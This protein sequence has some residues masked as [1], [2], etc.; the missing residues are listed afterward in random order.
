MS[1]PNSMMREDKWRALI[2][3]K[4]LSK[5]ADLVR[6]VLVETLTSK[7]SR[8][9]VQVSSRMHTKLAHAGL[10]VHRVHTD[11]SVSHGLEAGPV[12]WLSAKQTCISLSSAE[13]ELTA[14]LE[15]AL[16]MDCLVPLVEDMFVCQCL[17]NLYIRQ[18][19]LLCLPNFA[20]RLL[21]DQTPPAEGEK[22]AR[23][24]RGGA[25][26]ASSSRWSV[27]A[28]GPSDK[29][30]SGPRVRDLLHLMGFLLT[31]DGSEVCGGE[32]RVSSRLKS[33]LDEGPGWSPRC[34][35]E[36]LRGICPSIG[37]F[38]CFVSDHTERGLLSSRSCA[39]DK[40]SAWLW[41]EPIC[42]R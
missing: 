31:V 42:S 16:L 41:S 34:Q 6:I 39:S 20:G 21:E 10:P 11:S 13:S 30:L 8:E 36:A 26:Q 18:C 15:R 38:G 9:I 37:H 24:S 35:V 33:T 32:E 4:E 40:N 12:M 23:E 17:R 28:G 19:G 25:G 22:L 7:S 3:S 2:Y 27:H 5:P 14:A 29:P 1:R